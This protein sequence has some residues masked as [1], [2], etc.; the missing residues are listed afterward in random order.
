MVYFSGLLRLLA[1]TFVPSCVTL[2]R[3]CARSDCGLNLKEKVGG[4]SPEL[5]VACD[6]PILIESQ[7]S[8]TQ[9]S[10]ERVRE[11]GLT[12]TRLW[13]RW[14]LHRHCDCALSNSLSA[15]KWRSQYL[16]SLLSKTTP[17]C[18]PSE[19]LTTLPIDTESCSTSY[20]KLIFLFAS[21]LWVANNSFEEN[22]GC[23]QTIH[24]Y[25][26]ET[27]FLLSLCWKHTQKLGLL[28]N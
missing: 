18:L 14:G 10:S 6:S 5:L 1:K 11:K 7:F 19:K 13:A 4:C 23:K 26:V 16:T 27:H 8:R 9:K 3:F 22:W 12:W 15:N 28:K 17:T 2:I 20:A 21:I 25:F 24:D